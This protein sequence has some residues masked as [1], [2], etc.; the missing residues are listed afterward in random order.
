MFYH[1]R[2]RVFYK[3]EYCQYEFEDGEKDNFNS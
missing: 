3:N 2:A 1:L